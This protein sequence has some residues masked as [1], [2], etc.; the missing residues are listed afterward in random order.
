MRLNLLSLFFFPCRPE[1]EREGGQGG[2]ERDGAYQE[3]RS[4]TVHAPVWSLAPQ[5]VMC[6]GHLREQ[7]EQTKLEA[8]GI[9]L[10]SWMITLED[11]KC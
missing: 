6:I 10:S 8:R 2:R 1:I 3:G 5:A 4:E 7:G 11:G 9:N